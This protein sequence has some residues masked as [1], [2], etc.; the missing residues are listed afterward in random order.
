VCIATV[1]AH[2]I[3]DSSCSCFVSGGQ[4]QRAGVAC[5]P[6]SPGAADPCRRL[7]VVVV[8]A[9][10]VYKCSK[11]RVHLP[12]LLACTTPFAC[13]LPTRV[14]PLSCSLTAAFPV[15][16]RLGGEDA[17]H[18]ARDLYSSALL[19][20]LR[21]FKAAV[22]RPGVFRPGQPSQ[23]SRARCPSPCSLRSQAVLNVPAAATA[24]CTT[25]C[26]PKAKARSRG[27]AYA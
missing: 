14:P 17:E 11:S 10:Y 7:L 13:M 26:A 23:V 6:Q 25:P 15:Q 19:T 1:H 3:A 2:R 5:W 12:L 24:P 27:F 21:S 4:D 18:A 8:L 9:A 16:E 20:A 22:F